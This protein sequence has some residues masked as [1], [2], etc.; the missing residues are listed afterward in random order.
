MAY[1]AYAFPVVTQTFTVTE[2]AA[3]RER[4]VPIDVFAA[5]APDGP[6]LDPEAAEERARATYL[7]APFSLRAAAACAAWLVRRPWRFTRTF[8][9]C[10]RG[11]Y[12]DDGIRCRLRAP[13]HAACGA[14]LASVLRGRGGYRRIHAQF[15][16][17][18]STV[19]YVASRLLDVRLSIANHTAYNPFLL[20]V[21]CMHT[22]RMVSISAFDRDLLLRQAGGALDPA[23]TVVSRVGIRLG[24][25]DRLERRPEAGRILCVGA[26]REKKGH[27]D[28]IAAA[29]RLSREGTHV[30]VLVFAGA[31]PEEAALRASASG[32]G[33]RVEFLGAVG[34]ER[35]RAE[36]VRAEVFALPCR[37]ARNGDLDGIPVALMEAMAAGIPVVSTRLSGIPELVED[38]VSGLLVPPGDDAALA[39]ALRRLL[40]DPD[41]RGGLAA[42]GR[43]RV[44][45]LHDVE[46][47]S[48]QLASILAE[49]DS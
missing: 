42:A 29:A 33:V 7:P 26:L 21:K 3:L 37:M 32:A 5:K 27:R 9:S 46:R 10:L 19:A 24:A 23:R 44:A 38:G 22:D 12:A 4:G 49:G 2:V 20:R 16:D 1:V 35:I 34:R 18:G 47:T 41:L 14:A 39:A 13:L 8:L 43:T 36:M 25:W 15:L 31:G 30:P 45:A 28:L 40:G 11:G 17:A 6:D 48:A